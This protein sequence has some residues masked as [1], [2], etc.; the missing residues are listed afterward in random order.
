MAGIRVADVNQSFQ[1]PAQQ[2][3][4]IARL[5][6]H[7][8]Q[9]IEGLC[10]GLADLIVG[11]VQREDDAEV[12]LLAHPLEVR[13]FVGK[14]LAEHGSE[15]TVVLLQRF[16]DAAGRKIQFSQTAAV[17]LHLLDELE[18]RLPAG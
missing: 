5:Q 9:L 16:H 3:I 8:E 6:F 12:K 2:V 1:E 14:Q 15:Q 17:V 13:V 11:V 10:F 18:R 7:P 4:Q